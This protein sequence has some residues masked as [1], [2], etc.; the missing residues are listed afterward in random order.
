MSGAGIQFA[1][2]CRAIRSQRV[3]PLR[4]LMQAVNLFNVFYKQRSCS[5]GRRPKPEGVHVFALAVVGAQSDHI[6]LVGDDVDQL[7][8]TKETAGRGVPLARF[9]P[10]L[11]G[12]C[13]IFIVP[14]S[15]A[16]DWMRNPW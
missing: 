8:L 3:V 6:P 12:E 10:H 1:D 7:E 9:F 15:K 16:D 2:V 4:L 11:Y 14:V 5:L 13:K